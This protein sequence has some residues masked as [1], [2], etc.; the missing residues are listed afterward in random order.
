MKEDRYKHIMYT[1]DPSENISVL[2]LV[3]TRMCS[4]AGF[5]FLACWTVVKFDIKRIYLRCRSDNVHKNLCLRSKYNCCSFLL[6][7]YRST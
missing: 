1:Y 5:H 2:K 7:I 6:F 4:K 3:Y